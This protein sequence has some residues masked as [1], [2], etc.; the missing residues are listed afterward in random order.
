MANLRALLYTDAATFQYS[1][2]REFVVGHSTNTPSNGGCCCQ[3]TVPAGTAYIKFEIWGGGGGGGGACCCMMGHPGYSGSYGIKTLTGTQVVVGAVYTICAG[4]SSAVSSTN[5]GCGGFTSYVNGTNLSNFCAC[6]GFFGCTNC[7][8]FS[9]NCQQCAQCF[10][11]GGAFGADLCIYGTCG[12]SNI[13]MYCFNQGQQWAPVAAGT[14]SGPVFGPSG[15]SCTGYGESSLCAP[16][17][18]G[19]GGFA[20]QVYAGGCK[21]GYHGAGGAVSV[22]YG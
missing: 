1:N 5:A 7:C 10:Y 9:G 18:P 19:G 11:Q 4:G 14:V 8:A 21:C 20:A 12:A 15:C 6:G 22:T 17:F 16:V 13:T 2:L 3:W